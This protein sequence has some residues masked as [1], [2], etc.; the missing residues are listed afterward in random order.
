MKKGWKIFWI[1]CACVAGLGLILAIIGTVL[2]ATFGGVQRMFWEKGI[3][4]ERTVESLKNRMDCY[5]DYYDDDRW[6]ENNVSGGK[7][8]TNNTKVN[9]SGVAELDVDVP[10][11]QIE[12]QEGVGEDIVFQIRHI[13]EEIE[14]ELVL[15]QE[16]DE[17]DVKIR[18]ERK[19][20][21]V[22]HNRNKVGTL[23]I[24]I[25][26][27]KRFRT[28][29]L[30]VGAGVLN[31]DKIQTNELEVEVGAG[32]ANIT[33]FTAD[34]LDVE[35]GAGEVSIAGTTSVEA[36]IDCGIG[37][38]NYQADGR[39]QD[40]SYELECNAGVIRIGN[41]DYSGILNEKEI[42]NGGAL[43]EINCGVGEVDI[44]FTGK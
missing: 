28:M 29:K 42:L 39:Q 41:E 4:A 31:V 19:W 12:I 1:V 22:M 16:R 32:I 18:N 8:L 33:Q 5:D 37:K 23:S 27:E 9:V 44:Q 38:V 2:G 6:E 43:M 24:Q 40:Y 35:V 7:I 15:I 14:S 34:F 25:P 3:H 26:K 17:L 36:S 20:G 21:S 10:F 13:P 11:L 30:F